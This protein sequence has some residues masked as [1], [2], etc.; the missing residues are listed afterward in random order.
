MK[1]ADILT[2]LRGKYPRAAI[3]P[4]LSDPDTRQD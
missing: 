4:S 3:G 1:A 2:A